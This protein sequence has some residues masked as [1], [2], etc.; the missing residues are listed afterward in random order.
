[1]TNRT[2][3]R[4]DKSSV[5]SVLSLAMAR[6]VTAEADEPYTEILPHQVKRMDKVTAILQ[7]VEWETKQG[8][9]GSS[10][11]VKEVKHETM[12]CPDCEAVGRYDERGDIVC[13]NDCGRILNDDPLML[14]E[15]HFSGRASG[16]VS[17]TGKQALNPANN[18][19][20][21]EPDV[22]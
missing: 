18:N 14:P 7:Q 13:S 3:C 2:N 21:P 17:G 15:D 9:Y 10:T 8:A 19:H 4:A 12:A 1:M 20:A 16:D 22:Q 5:E 11:L 6:P